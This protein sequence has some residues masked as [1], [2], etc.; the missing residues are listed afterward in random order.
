MTSNGHSAFIVGLPI[1]DTQPLAPLTGVQDE[2]CITIDQLRYLVR[3]I[4]QSDVAELE[5]L[6]GAQKARLLLRKAK[7]LSGEVSIESGHTQGTLQHADE[8]AAF[9]TSAPQAHYTITAPLV[10]IFQSW[11]KSKDKPLIAVGDTIKEGQHVG[12][13]RSLDMP[14]EV[15]APVAG[16]VV[17][18]L[19]QDGQP[20]EY[21]QP[22]MTIDKA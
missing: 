2:E 19:V 4:D 15:E 20:I 9:H 10:G 8:E 14:N 11:S 1:Q 22:L 13:I 12:V 6:H 16:R 3:L 18:M 5:M 7:P 17:E 21:G